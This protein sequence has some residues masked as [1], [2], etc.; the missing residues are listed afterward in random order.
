MKKK[1]DAS[2]GEL[3]FVQGGP[4]IHLDDSKF[5]KKEQH[6]LAKHNRDVIVEVRNCAMFLSAVQVMVGKVGP[7]SFDSSLDIRED[8]ATDN[9]LLT[10]FGNF[11][12]PPNISPRILGRSIGK[13]GKHSGLSYHIGYIKSITMCCHCYQSLSSG[14]SGVLI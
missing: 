9:L 7:L 2:S 4:M 12:T 1:G 5:T 14:H 8:V 11:S 3:L 10:T 6:A 13:T